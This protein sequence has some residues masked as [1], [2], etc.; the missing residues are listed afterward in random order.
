MNIDVKY[1]SEAA[2]G[3]WRTS[4]PA[5]A[6][7]VRLSWPDGIDVRRVNWLRGFGD[8]VVA[9]TVNVVIMTKLTRD[10]CAR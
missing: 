1:G 8:A 6:Y 7:R 3:Y 9:A 5:P 2:I 4:D 10:A